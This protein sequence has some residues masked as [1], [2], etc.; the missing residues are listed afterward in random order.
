VDRVARLLLLLLILAIA[1]WRLVRYLK[2]A[3]GKRPVSV[4]SGAGMIVQTAAPTPD[5][6]QPAPSSS[7]PSRLTL[8]AGILIGATFWVVTNLAIVLTLFGLPYLRDLPPIMLLVAIVLS[9]FYLIPRARRLADTWVSRR[10]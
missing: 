3:M 4:A 8:L 2:L 1:G 5:T 6:A 10:P 7:P 9:N